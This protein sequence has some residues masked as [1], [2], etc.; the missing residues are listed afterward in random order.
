MGS[1]T[2]HEHAI[3]RVSPLNEQDQPAAIWRVAGSLGMWYLY[4]G[5]AFWP[6]IMVK[7]VRLV[8]KYQELPLH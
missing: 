4:L 6:R 5:Q 2:V 7:G 1:N 8:P 3:Y